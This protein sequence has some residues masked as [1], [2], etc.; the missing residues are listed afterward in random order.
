M[1]PLLGKGEFPIKDEHYGDFVVQELGRV[2]CESS[3]R[4]S[5]E[6]KELLVRQER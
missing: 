5:S 6:V 2:L 4:E 3:S 1:N